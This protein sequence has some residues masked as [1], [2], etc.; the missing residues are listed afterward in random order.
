MSFFPIFGLDEVML[1]VKY[2]RYLKI[3]S[4]FELSKVTLVAKFCRA[5]LPRWED[6]QIRQFCPKP[7]YMMSS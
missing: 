7:G 5:C 3:T 2:L 1:G 6:M 4:I